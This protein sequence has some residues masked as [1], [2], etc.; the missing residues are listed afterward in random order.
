MSQT[1]P[2]VWSW[3]CSGCGV[4]VP[5][6]TVHECSLYS[7]PRTLSVKTLPDADV[8][9]AL[10]TALTSITQ[11]AERA[12]QRAEGLDAELQRALAV[13]RAAESVALLGD[14][15]GD[16]CVQCGECY[17]CQL[18]SALAAWEAP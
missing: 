6:G 12:Q 15:D 10:Q 3:R 2:G 18:R 4:S 17:R 14:F 7:P 11:I 1:W 16:L 9:A 13:V 8:I 5:A